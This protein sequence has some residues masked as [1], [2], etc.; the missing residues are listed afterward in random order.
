MA[1]NLC[2]ILAEKIETILSRNVTNTRGRDFYDAYILLSM[3]R[4]TL[5]REELLHALRVKAKE[6]DSISFIENY[7]KHL[8][9]IAGSPEIEKIWAGYTKSYPY[10]KGIALPDI[11]ALIAWV[12]E[13]DNLTNLIR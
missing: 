10:A 12:L 5:A 13:N 6:R 7:A 11:L 2:T 9:D 1:Y 4:D 3:N 8:R